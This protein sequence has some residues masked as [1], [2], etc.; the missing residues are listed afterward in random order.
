MLPSIPCPAHQS[1]KSLTT[2]PHWRSSAKPSSVSPAARRGERWHPKPAILQPLHELLCLSR[3]VYRGHELLP[4]SA[5]GEVSRAAAAIVLAFVDLT[6]AF[7][8]VRRSGL[9]HI[10]QKTGCLPKL[11]AIIT[12]L[13]QNIRST[14]YFDGATGLRSLPTH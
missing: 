13:H 3:E 1:W 10:L 6:K 9:F 14:I 4:P 8:L 2:C 12:A 7:D 11:H 5:A